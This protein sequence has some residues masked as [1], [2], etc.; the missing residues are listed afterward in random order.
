MLKESHLLKVGYIWVCCFYFIGGNLKA[1]LLFAPELNFFKMLL[2]LCNNIITCSINTH[3]LKEALHP[4]QVEGN[5]SHGDKYKLD[6]SKDLQMYGHL[7]Q[8]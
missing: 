6:E 4:H 8:Y 5:D 2:L 3:C 1:V 7:Q